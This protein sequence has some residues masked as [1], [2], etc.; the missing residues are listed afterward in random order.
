VDCVKHSRKR[1]RL[2]EEHLEVLDRLFLRAV[3]HELFEELMMYVTML[4]IWDVCID[5]ESN[6]IQDEIC[7][8]AQDAECS[9]AEGAEARVM[10]G[11]SATHCIYH[12]LADFD[13]RRI[14]L[15][16]AT[17]DVSKVHYTKHMSKKYQA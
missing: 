12:F 4:D 6:E 15:R 17:K 8:V 2:I 7:R 14:G 3:K 16:V 9:V 13:G 11:L 5:H 1:A 10:R